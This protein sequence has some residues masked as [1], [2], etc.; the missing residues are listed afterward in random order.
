MENEFEQTPGPGPA[1]SPSVPQVSP[2]LG[3]DP[4]TGQPLPPA[5]PAPDEKKLLA[6]VWHTLLIVLLVVGNS[7]VSWWMSHSIVS[8]SVVITE[9]ARLLQ[10]TFT[11]VLEFFLLFLTWVGLRLNKKRLRDVIGGRWDTPEAVLIDVAIAAGFWIV[12]FGVLAAMGYALGLGKQSQLPEAKKLI[13]ALA[14]HSIGGLGI[15]VLLSCVAGFVEEILFRGYLQKQISLLSGNV[16]VG[17]L[18]SALVFGA[19]HGYQGTRRM[20]VIAVYGILFGLLVQW[21]KSL[22]PGM[23]AHAW[24]DA[25]EGT[26]LFFVVRFHLDRMM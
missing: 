11:I 15:F 14:P 2:A 12:A 6:P 7:V 16:Y 19:G 5:S 17:L 23:I 20:I 13:E 8:K 18:V 25:F 3:L 26:L 1:A 9:K 24:H 22:R 10:Y 4:V 21:R